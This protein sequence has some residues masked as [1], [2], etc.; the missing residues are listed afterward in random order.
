V[1]VEYVTRFPEISRVEGMRRGIFGAWSIFVVIFPLIGFGFLVSGISYGIKANQLLSMGKITF[2]KLISTE[3]TGVRVNRRPVLKLT[4]SFLSEA[5]Q[6]WEVTAKTHEPGDLR[7]EEEEP[8]LYDPDDPSYAVLMDNLPGSTEFDASGQLLPA[9][10]WE[11]LK[12][13]FLPGLTVVGHGIY[14]V[15]SNL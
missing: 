8:I 10:I 4:F 3:S 15:L 7:D 11:I 5:G 1:N 14:L 6:D 12:V 9:S 2:G 13:L